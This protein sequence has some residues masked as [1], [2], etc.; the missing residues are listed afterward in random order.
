MFLSVRFRVIKPHRLFILSSMCLLL[1][2]LVILVLSKATANMAPTNCV[3]RCRKC[4]S[5]LRLQSLPTQSTWAT[6]NLRC[7]LRG[8]LCRCLQKSCGLRKNLLR[9]ETLLG[10]VVLLRALLPVRRRA[11]MLGQIPCWT[12]LVLVS[13][14]RLPMNTLS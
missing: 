11:G 9:I 14:S 3:L 5:L 1:S 2:R 13:I 7:P 12:T 4:P 6:P 10:R 8:N